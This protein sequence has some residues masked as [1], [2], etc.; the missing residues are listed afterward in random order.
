MGHR[1]KPLRAHENAFIDAD[2]RFTDAG[3]YELR[4]LSIEAY[5]Y[6]IGRRKR[7]AATFNRKG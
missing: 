4:K 5:E 1:T 7:E 6:I 2:G 3:L